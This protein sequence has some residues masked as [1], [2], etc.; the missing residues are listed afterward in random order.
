MAAI[1]QAVAQ[2]IAKAMTVNSVETVAEAESMDA[3]TFWI[4]F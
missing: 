2:A 3:A 1:V 4:F